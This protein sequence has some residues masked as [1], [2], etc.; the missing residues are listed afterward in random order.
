[1]HITTASTSIWRAKAVSQII[2]VLEEVDALM[3]TRLKMDFGLSDILASSLNFL[4]VFWR[5]YTA[6]GIIYPLY[7]SVLS[8]N[9]WLAIAQFSILASLINRRLETA[10]EALD[11]LKMRSDSPYKDQKVAILSDVHNKLCDAGEILHTAFSC[12]L[13]V[14]VAVILVGLIAFAFSFALILSYSYVFTSKGSEYLEKA[15]KVTLLCFVNSLAIMHITTA[16]TSIRRVRDL[17]QIIGILEE[18]D[19][20]LNIH[21]QLDFCLSDFL[22]LSLNFLVIFCRSHRAGYEIGEI[23]LSV[24]LVSNIWLAMS[25]FSVLSSLITSR[26]EEACETLNELKMRSDSPYK[27]QKVAI[28]SNVH[29]KLC[30]AGEIL[31]TAFTC[32]LTV[33]IAVCFV[34][35][36]VLTFHLYSAHERN[37]NFDI[38]LLLFQDEKVLLIISFFTTIWKIAAS[39]SE[40]TQKVFNLPNYIYKS[41]AT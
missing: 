40:L 33:M 9:L 35:I 6:E 2:S 30:D 12:L 13:T 21:L 3:N 31:H 34:G 7:C 26:L 39:S 11:E 1:M 8:I 22:A 41:G 23:L 4:V 16:S 25:Q 37:E 27:D 19:A 10:C 36:T 29:N 5:W 18:V 17:R 38:R 32:L 20:I 15:D 28:L 24:I 14:L